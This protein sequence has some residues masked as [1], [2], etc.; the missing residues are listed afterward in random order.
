MEECDGGQQACSGVCGLARRREGAGVV[1][2]GTPIVG[3]VSDDADDS[4]KS[5]IVEKLMLLCAFPQRGGMLSL[6]RVSC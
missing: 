4:N 3:A 2:H 5:D 1:A 6:G